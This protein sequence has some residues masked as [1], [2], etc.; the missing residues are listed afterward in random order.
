MLAAEALVIGALAAPE[1]LGGDNVV[2]SLPSQL[3]QHPEDEQ[4]DQ[5]AGPQSGVFAAACDHPNRRERRPAAVLRMLGS[6]AGQRHMVFKASQVPWNNPP[7]DRVFAVID[8]QCYL[9][10]ATHCP[11]RQ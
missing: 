4:S 5:G 10:S 1:D 8:L 9:P 2:R 3:L 7:S 11:K 6:M